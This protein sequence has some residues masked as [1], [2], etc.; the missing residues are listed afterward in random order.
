MLGLGTDVINSNIFA[1]P[2]WPVHMFN[3]FGTIDNM[4]SRHCHCKHHEGS[5]D[6]LDSFCTEAV[7]CCLIKRS[8][9]W[10]RDG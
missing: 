1:F 9:G 7:Q 2:S 4:Y 8:S 5:V 10:F 6:R 3:T